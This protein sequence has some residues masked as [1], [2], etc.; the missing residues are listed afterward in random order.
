MTKAN[1]DQVTTDAYVQSCQKDFWQEVFA[2]ELDYLLPHLQT[3]DHILSIGCGPAMIEKGL[4]ERGFE[5]TGLDVSAE[6]IAA[7]PDSLRTVVAPAEQMPFTDADFDVVLFIVSLQFIDNLHQALAEAG[8]VLKPGGKL[9]AMLLNPKSAFFRCRK[10]QPNSYIGKIR[11]TDL[12]DIEAAITAK[13]DAHSEYFLGID[14]ERLFVS[15]DPEK[16]ALYVVY[17]R[18]SPAAARNEG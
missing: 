16:A 3:G 15:R 18:K 17:G 4:Q 11:H 9:I 6:A 7:A 8:R 14:K 5:V 2:A 10:I 12:Q 1:D 13:F